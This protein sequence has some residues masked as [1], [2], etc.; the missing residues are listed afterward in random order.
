MYI[1]PQH[2][3]E[4]ETQD[5]WKELNGTSTPWAQGGIYEVLKQYAVE[6][7]SSAQDVRLRS[8]GRGDANYTW[9]V[10]SSGYVG[11]NINASN[12]YRFEP[13]MFI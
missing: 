8:A 3:G 2:T 7:H 11:S 5:Y 13:L 12:A 10:Y 4:G 6:N 1:N 9:L